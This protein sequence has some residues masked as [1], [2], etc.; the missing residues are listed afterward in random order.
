MELAN[1]INLLK[2]HRYTIIIIPIIAVIITYFLT[3]NQPNNYSSQA[4]LATGI[5]DQTQNIINEGADAQESKISQEFS[6]LTEMFRSKK[7]LDQ[8][9]YFLIIH[10]LTSKTPYRKPSKLLTQ[11]N[12]NAKK[13]ALQ[14]FTDLYNQRGAL[15]LFDSDQ[16]GLNVLL[17]SM[18]YDD[19][20]L[21]NSLT[22]FRIQNSDYIQVQFDSESANLSADVVNQ[23]CKEFIDYYTFLVKDNQRKA[24]DFWGGLLASKEAAL[25]QR[26]AD[27]KAYKIKNHVL[28]LNEKAKSIYGQITDFETRREDIEK[29][30]QATQAAINNIDKQFDP[31]SRKYIESTKTEASRQILTERDQLQALNNAYIQNNFDPKYKK[32]IDSVS[33]LIST[34]IESLSDK[35]VINPLNAKQ[36]LIQQKLSLQVQNDLAKNSEGAVTKELDR[37]TREFDSLVPHEGTIQALESAIAVASQEYLEI[38]VK[39]NQTNMV[40]KVSVQ[41]RLLERAQPGSAQPS[42]KM[43]L[44]ILSGVI[45]FIFCVVIFFLLYIFDSTIKSA[46]ELANKTKLPVLGHISLLKGKSLDL[47][48][49]WTNSAQSEDTK[50]FRNLMQS[51]RY[52]VANDLA[53]EKVLLVNSSAQGEGKTFVAINLAYAFSTVC[54]NVLLIDGNFKGEGI[55]DFA[56]SKFYLEDFLTGNLDQSFFTENHTIKVLCNRGNDVSILEISQA[57][58][59]AAKLETLKNLFDIIIIESPA[60]DTL[61]KS[62][63]W[64]SFA[65]KIVTV[66]ESG[67]VIS[68]QINQ[69]IEYLKSLN[70][71]FIGWI[72]NM[73][74]PEHQ[75]DKSK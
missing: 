59:I 39:F 28:N 20:S 57:E 60:L 37:L 25:N 19:Q 42:K 65:N 73:E 15:S 68:D 13:H 36:D 46:R 72:F 71:K 74:Q 49:L 61:N 56:N 63:E 62:K 34:N 35:Y 21:L 53:N 45:S 31:T 14:V 10:D 30:V 50:N 27:L 75:N 51:I 40:A 64:T 66:F 32:Q 38:L 2:K 48:E 58:N 67:Q 1:F 29:N 33:H 18:K 3:K 8:V 16:N 9:S 6:N 17:G 24:V 43:L 69:N 12:P 47:R 70:G 11:L 22:L 7:V 4:V 55:S 23:V 44:I 26:M 41:L 5:V 54:E 52:E